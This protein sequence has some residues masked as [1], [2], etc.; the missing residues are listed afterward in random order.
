M[1]QEE[2]LANLA[3]IRIPLSF[4][5]FTFRDALLA[6]CLGLLVGLLLVKVIALVTTRKVS[7]VDQVRADIAK[8]ATLKEEARLVGLAELLKRY[9]EP[10]AGRLGLLEAMYNPS[11][12]TDPVLL[13]QAIMTAARSAK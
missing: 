8:L 7:R 3:P 2:L 1:T 12:S 11:V 9:D 4:A 6:L 13:E 5:E 10:A